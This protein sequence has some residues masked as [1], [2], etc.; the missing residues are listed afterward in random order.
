[1]QGKNARYRCDSN[2]KYSHYEDAE[3][4]ALWLSRV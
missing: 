3:E 4:F 2:T 1:M